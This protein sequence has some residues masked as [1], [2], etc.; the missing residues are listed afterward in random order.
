MNDY[1]DFMSPNLRILN[2]N[3]IK[4]NNKNIFYPNMKEEDRVQAWR[5]MTQYE[6]EYLFG[7]DYLE[8]KEEKKSY[9]QWLYWL[10]GPEPG[11]D[12]DILDNGLEH[13]NECI[14]SEFKMWLDYGNYYVEPQ[15]D[16]EVEEHFYKRSL[17]ALLFQFIQQVATKQ[18]SFIDN[19]YKR[20]IDS[21]RVYNMMY[22]EAMEKYI[23]ENIVDYNFSSDLDEALKADRKH[24]EI[25][26]SQQ[27]REMSR[28]SSSR[29][30]SVDKQRLLN[31]YKI[32]KLCKYK[33]TIKLYL[34]WY[35]TCYMK[36]EYK[37][38]LTNQ[39]WW[40]KYCV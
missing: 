33:N 4:K 12:I 18:N 23:R 27:E 2:S 17:S 16:D 20:V 22:K 15:R 36:N 6:K 38:I 14:K 34:K 21:S 32:V 31:K 10:Y 40:K 24:L 11:Q 8:N 13:L 37:Y 9:F 30:F 25:L 28:F 35:I 7:N 1:D 19:Y 29:Y 5:N 26:H 3:V 39:E